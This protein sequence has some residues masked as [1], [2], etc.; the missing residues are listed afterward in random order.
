M[1]FHV[2]NSNT[3]YALSQMIY[4]L[5]NYLDSFNVGEY[6]FS[7]SI[8]DHGSWL[9]CDGRS[10]SKSEYGELYNI[11]STNY[12]STDSAHFNL[13]DFTGKIFGQ[14]GNGH[15]I[16]DSVGSE[17]VTLTTPQIPSHVH[18]GTTVSA[19]VHNHTATTDNQG[20]H[21]HTASTDS[22]GAH[23]H[24]SNAIGGQGNYGLVTA[25]GTNTVTGTDPSSGELNVWTTPFALSINNGG[26][27]NHAVT[28]ANNGLHNHAVTVANNGAHTHT[29]TTNATG[30]GGS[31]PN[32]QPTLF[33]GNVFILSKKL[34]D[35]LEIPSI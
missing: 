5:S 4:L 21:N 10:L 15:D 6:K 2:N 19:G 23:T 25:D 33:G 18:D 28:V 3:S 30:S 16:G 9:I 24:T 14:I 1:S 26:T 35:M 34:N 20:T 13:P 22:Q 27:H 17:T 31:H 32:M 11:I 29:F 12:G 8:E 7:N